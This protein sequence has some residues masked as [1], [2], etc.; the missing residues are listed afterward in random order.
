M[1]DGA[2]MGLPVEVPVGEVKRKKDFAQSISLCAELAGYNLD[3]QATAGIAMDKGQW[4]RIKG[5]REGIKW[6]RLKKFMDCMGNSAPVLWMAHDMGW[7]IGS[8]RRQE[9]EHEMRIRQLEEENQQ[10]RMEREVL[11]KAIRG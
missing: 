11:A 3:K 4:S 1:S 7:D 8:F 6:G 9:T 5:E 2:Q 10:L